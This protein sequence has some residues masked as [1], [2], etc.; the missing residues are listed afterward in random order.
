M[1]R[2]SRDDEK[3]DLDRWL[4]AREGTCVLCG[5]P[6]AVQVR[7]SLRRCAKQHGMRNVST[8]LCAIYPV[9]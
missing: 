3:T 1:T 8:R 7:L 4:V 5:S 2:L 9:L 6:A